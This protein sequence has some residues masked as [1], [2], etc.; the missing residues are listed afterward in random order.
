VS[1]P[2]LAAIIAFN[3]LA[4]VALGV[5]LRYL[6]DAPRPAQYGFG[7]AVLLLLAAVAGLSATALV[8]N[9]RRPRGLDPDALQ[10]AP[11]AGQAER[12]QGL[13]RRATDVGAADVARII[14]A[15]EAVG[16]RPQWA[17]ERLDEMNALDLEPPEGGN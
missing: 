11:P 2:L 16:S 7:A 5:T 3:V 12:R 6:A 1:R 9:T 13:G 14:Q 8:T 10:G 4:F 15:V 17:Q